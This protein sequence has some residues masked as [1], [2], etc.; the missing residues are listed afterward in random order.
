M[1]TASSNKLRSWIRRIWTRSSNVTVTLDGIQI[2]WR[3]RVKLFILITSWE[4]FSHGSIDW[5]ELSVTYVNLW[6]TMRRI[7]IDIIGYPIATENSMMLEAIAVVGNGIKV[8]CVLCRSW[9]IHVLL[10]IRIGL[11]NL[12]VSTCDL[13]VRGAQQWT[14]MLLGNK[15]T[16]GRVTTDNGQHREISVVSSQIVSAAHFPVLEHRQC[17]RVPEVCYKNC[18]VG[19]RLKLKVWCK[20]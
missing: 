4:S 1:I 20:L 8:E 6:C 3:C 5:A 18:L 17:V 12:V 15:A 9:T 10:W 19:Y 14:R 7:S 16:P 13:W 2:G 11:L